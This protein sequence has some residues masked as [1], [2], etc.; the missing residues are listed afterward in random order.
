MILHALHLEGAQKILWYMQLLVE[1][2]IRA[3]TL[4]WHYFT[5]LKLFFR[6]GKAIAH[7]KQ[8]FN[9]VAAVTHCKKSVKEVAD[10]I[11]ASVLPGKIM[12]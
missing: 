2:L 12:L 9:K 10:F 11:R 6:S 3:F 5:S 4:R 7:S 8:A 1:T